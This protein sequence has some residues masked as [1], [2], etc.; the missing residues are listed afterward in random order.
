MLRS[1]CPICDKVF[2]PTK[3]QVSRLARGNKA[4]CTRACRDESI[5]IKYRTSRRFKK[6]EKQ[7]LLK[8]KAIKIQGCI[9]PGC[10]HDFS[11][12]ENLVLLM[13][14][15]KSHVHSRKCRKTEEFFY[16]CRNCNGAQTKNCGSWKKVGCFQ[17]LCA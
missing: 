13:V 5:K 10:G 6:I 1:K 2:I 8:L 9:C 7:R 17:K 11:S 16:S 15:E 4:Y 3:I 14:F 12:C